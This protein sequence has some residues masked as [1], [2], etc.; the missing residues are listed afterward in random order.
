MQPKLKRARAAAGQYEPLTTPHDWTGDERRFALKITQLM[1]ELFQRQA[2]L[3][4]RL[5]ALE[6]KGKEESDGSF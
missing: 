2:A 6:R 1:D 3:S 5:A 4:A